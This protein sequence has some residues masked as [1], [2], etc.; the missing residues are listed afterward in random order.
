[1]EDVTMSEQWQYYTTFLYADAERQRDFLEGRWPSGQL[2]K[3]AAESMIPELD[4][5]GA[6]GWELVHMEPV[7][8]VGKKGDVSFTRGYGTM[9]VWSNAYFCVFKRPR[10]A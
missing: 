9:T 6:E 8:G 5:L 7:G 3:Y 4:E 2:P 10:A 1:M